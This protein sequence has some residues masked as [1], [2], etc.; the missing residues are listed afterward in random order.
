VSGTTELSSDLVSAEKK[1]APTQSYFTSLGVA[2]RANTAKKHSL[3]FRLTCDSGQAE[4]DR[5]CDGL[6]SDSGQQLR[7]GWV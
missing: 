3:S 4:I 6:L 2:Q 5:F 1:K 7:C